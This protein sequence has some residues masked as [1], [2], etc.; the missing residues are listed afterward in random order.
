MFGG[1]DIGKWSIIHSY[2]SA[3]VPGVY[4]NPK[5]MI[6]SKGSDCCRSGKIIRL[7]Q[8]AER[9]PASGKPLIGAKGHGL[10]GFLIH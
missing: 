7:L 10:G 3:N 4:A 6:G 2:G 1:L 5:T 9:E 8:G